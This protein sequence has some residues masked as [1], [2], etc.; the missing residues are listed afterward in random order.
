M[1][2]NHLIEYQSFI[3]DPQPSKIWCGP[4]LARCLKDGTPNPSWR[5]FYRGLAQAS[6]NKTITILD[7]FFNYLVQT[8]YLIGNPLAIE[9]KR[10]RRNNKPLQIIDRYLEMDEINAT[11]KFRLAIGLPS[12]QPNSYVT[13][14]LDSGADLKVAQENAGHSDIS[15]TM[16]YRHMAQTDR[17][18]ATRFLSL[19]KPKLPKPR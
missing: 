11:A 8:N 15:T 12:S 5:P 10:K 2:R 13:Y 4:K 17:H 6:L 18:A 1:R 3:K 14:L 19:E 16:N 7:A 9:R